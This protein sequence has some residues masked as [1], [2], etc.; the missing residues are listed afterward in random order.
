MTGK[1]RLELFVRHAAP[2]GPWSQ[3]SGLLAAVSLLLILLVFVLLLP[4]PPASAQ[5]S[6]WVLTETIVNPDGHGLEFYGGGSTPG[7]YSEPRYEGKYQVYAVTE[8]SFSVDDRSV[9]SGEEWY[10]ITFR[11]SFDAPPAVLVPGETYPL[12]MDF[13]HSGSVKKGNPSVGF[14][15]ISP[16]VAIGSETPLADNTL[17]YSPWAEVPSTVSSM[18]WLLRPPPAGQAGSTLEIYAQ[19]WNAP[20]CVVKWKY[21]ARAAAPEHGVIEIDGVI[22]LVSPPGGVLRISRADLPEWARDAVATVGDE[23]ACVGP[24]ATL[25]EG[26]STVLLDGK[27]VARVGDGTSHGGTVVTGDS[28]ILVNGVPAATIGDY[29]TCPMVT[30]NIPHVG[31]PIAGRPGT[32]TSSTSTS[33]PSDAG[34]PP[35]RTFTD[36]EFER[37]KAEVEKVSTLPDGYIGV[38]IA[39]TGDFEVFDHRGEPVRGTRDRYLKPEAVGTVHQM[40][41]IGDTIRTS[42]KGR[43][44]VEMADRDD[45]RD[46]GPTVLNIS[47]NSEASF[48]DFRAPGAGSGL[49]TSSAIN[50][51]KGAVRAIFQG[52][53]GEA[54][55]SIRTGNTICG[56]RG[57]DVLIFYDPVVEVVV[58]SVNEGHVDVTS[59]LTGEVVS[60]TDGQVVIAWAGVF[61]PVL[62]MTQQDW[63]DTVAGYGV[64]D[65]QPFSP[66]ERERLVGIGEGSAVFPEARE[67]KMSPGLL[68]LIIVPAIVVVAAIGA[69]IYLL[70]RSRRKSREGA[71]AD[72]VAPA[73]TPPASSGFC[74]HCGSA[75]E[76]GATFCGGCGSRL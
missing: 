16:S 44:R 54:A 45:R 74:R 39:A 66:E 3:G 26:D 48:T 34:Q 13:S 18:T 49:D 24:P 19:W 11:S 28:R 38:I 71:T 5:E 33:G 7:Y 50:L 67:T 36:E 17:W 55:L 20:A 32:A 23:V 21:E 8:T 9:D 37:K 65:M 27:P 62:T 70:G 76:S 64:E 31:G 29:V 14:R 75:V 43:V 63:N 57:S 10:H 2:G 73:V 47:V 46:T 68:A 61:D 40:I 58:A 6:R 12:R 4:A 52:W 72:T 22:H 69:V 25:T 59:T 60:L 15:Y 1:H 30:G 56:I 41:R 51:I 35:P 53:R 42:D